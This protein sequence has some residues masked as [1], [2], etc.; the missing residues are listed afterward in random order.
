M[1]QA[2][3]LAKGGSNFNST[4]NLSL[5]TGVTGTLPVANGGTGA[6]TQ[7][8]AAANV[9]PSQTSNTGKYLTT[10]GTNTSWGTV[11][12]NPGTVTS[13]TAGTGLSGGT[14]TS[15]GT[16]A[17]A[18]TAVTAGSYTNASVTVNAQGQLTA[19]SSGTAPVTSVTGTS[20]IVS[21]GGATPAISHAT[22]GVTAASY[23]NANITVNA[24]GHITAAS[25]GASASG[26]VTSVATGNGLSGGTITTSGT[27]VVACPTF[28]S[29]GSYCWGNINYNSA[30]AGSNYSAGSSSQ[31]IQ[32]L[33]TR[34]QGDLSLA[35]NGRQFDVLSGTWKWMG[36]S[37]TD[38]E[39]RQLQTL[40]CRV[41]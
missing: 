35:L 22:S 17:V 12:S 11:T 21:S 34:N 16:I 15:S 5:T 1:T 8:G 19:A 31:Q 33:V 6:T 3:N 9:L 30:S 28:N 7:A 20:P 10:D 40:V 32:S 41:S 18:N 14:I 36:A 29:V 38:D 2:S 4:G 26:T 25:S 13:I 27:L 24:Q 37:F 39:G 23:T